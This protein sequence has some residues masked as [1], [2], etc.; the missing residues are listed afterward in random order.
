MQVAKLLVSPRTRGST[1]HGQHLLWLLTGFPADAGI[2]L[3]GTREDTGRSRGYR[4]NRIGDG[5]RRI[6]S[7]GVG[8]GERQRCTSRKEE[9]KPK[10][11]DDVA[12]LTEL[13]VRRHRHG[14]GYGTGCEIYGAGYGTGYGI[15]GAGYGALREP[16]SQP[17]AAT[18][19]AAESTV[20]VRPNR[21]TVHDHGLL[22]RS[23]RVERQ[24]R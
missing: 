9:Y 3:E 10:E 15:F 1:L 8:P 18:A 16:A 11:P 5:E 24:P 23:R 21:R 12:G 22:V 2:D 14:A 4:G 20:S 6:R 17:S 13:I 7:P 19:Q